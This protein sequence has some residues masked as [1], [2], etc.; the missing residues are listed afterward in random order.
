LSVKHDM[1]LKDIPSIFV[2]QAY[3]LSIAV[4]YNIF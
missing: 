3:H 4:P 2:S 1:V